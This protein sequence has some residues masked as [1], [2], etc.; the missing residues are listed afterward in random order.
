MA[1]RPS[2]YIVLSGRPQLRPGPVQTNAPVGPSIG[3]VATHLLRTHFFRLALYK[4]GLCRETFAK[5]HFDVQV[6]P[7][8]RDISRIS[9][10]LIKEPCSQVLSL[11]HARLV[12]RGS[13]GGN[14]R[15]STGRH[16]FRGPGMDLYGQGA[17]MLVLARPGKLLPHCGRSSFGFCGENAIFRPTNQ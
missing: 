11:V 10:D 14:L 13:W 17:G 6:S 9:R 3:P 4:S 12:Q 8:R 5:R 1:D 15:G 7:F 16:R 2:F